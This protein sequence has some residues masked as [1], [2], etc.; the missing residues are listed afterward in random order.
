MN[1]TELN[2]SKCSSQIYEPLHGPV[3]QVGRAVGWIHSGDVHRSS[4]A[5][6]QLHHTPL[7]ATSREALD[8]FLA[9]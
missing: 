7:L 6:E 9:L 8:S 3:E 4:P 2:T 5:A 1:T